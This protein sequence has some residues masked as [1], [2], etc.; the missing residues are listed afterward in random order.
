[1]RPKTWPVPAGP[2]TGSWDVRWVQA[3]GL[4]WSVWDAWVAS[5]APQTEALPPQDSEGQ[6]P[7]LPGARHGLPPATR[8]EVPAGRFCAPSLPLAL[9]WLLS[10]RVGGGLH[11]L[12]SEP[13]VPLGTDGTLPGAFGVRGTSPGSSALGFTSA[14]LPPSWPRRPTGGTAGTAPPSSHLLSSRPVCTHVPGSRPG[15]GRPRP[16]VCVCISRSY[17]P[18]NFWKLR[19][20]RNHGV[21]SLQQPEVRGGVLL[22]A[23]GF[24][25]PAPE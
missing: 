13:P 8:P 21:S 6:V 7:L 16:H 10:E 2:G 3:P 9:P 22:G 12:G 20:A 15:R 23:D 24:V 14:T 11:A 4:G 25:T 18:G 5:G 1:M 19:E 17:L